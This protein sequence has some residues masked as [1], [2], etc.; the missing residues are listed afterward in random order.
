MTMA[1]DARRVYGWIAAAAVVLTLAVVVASAYLRH[2]GSATVVT[3]GVEPSAFV[4][5]ARLLHRLSATA[6]AAAILALLLVTWTQRPVWLREAL[7]ATAALVVTAALA[8][9][10]VVTPGSTSPAVVLGNLLGGYT[11]LA[12]VAAAWAFASPAND[13]RAA[14]RVVA[15]VALAGA[16]VATACGIARP[17]DASHWIV[18]IAFVGLAAV[19]AFRLRRDRPRV[20]A[21]LSAALAVG[22][23]SGFVADAAPS[24]AVLH[25][26]ATAIAVAALAT[27]VAKPRPTAVSA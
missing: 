18:S 23:A 2:S 25:N 4:R 9:L 24:A 16:F 10:G 1:V 6:V 19:V 8:V 20:A 11:L 7:V 5:G 15:L 14:T 26:A 3:S 21:T 13:T 17:A 22:L 12:L 27:V